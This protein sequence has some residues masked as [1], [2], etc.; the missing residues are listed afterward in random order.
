MKNKKTILVV[1]AVAVLAVV[2]TAANFM[3]KG[4]MFSGSLTGSTTP[5]VRTTTTTSLAAP[6]LSLSADS[7][8]LTWEAVSG[9]TGY[10]IFLGGNWLASVD[11]ILS[12]KWFP[13]TGTYTVRTRKGM[14]TSSMSN[15]IAVLN[16][17]VL[18]LSADST[19]LNW[20]AVAGATSYDVYLNNVAEAIGVTSP[21]FLPKTPTGSASSYKVKANNSVGGTMSSAI[22]VLA[23]PVLSLSTDGTKLNWTTVASAAGYDIYV[24]GV[25]EAPDSSAPFVLGTLAPG[26]YNYTVRA[27]YSAS[28]SGQ[29]SG[30]ISVKK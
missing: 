24:N 26:T 13:Y 16:A 21:Y 17:P 11:N 15:G 5:I 19:K 22:A 2:I 10:E 3:G 12:H 27:K 14:A 30:V 23:A 28:I 7:T 9:A 6:V 1:V 4:E 29:I 20:V 8:L 25:M 18:S